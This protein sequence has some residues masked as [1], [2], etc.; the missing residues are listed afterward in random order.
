MKNSKFII[1][2][3]LTNK[4]L[5]YFQNSHVAETGLRD[6]HKMISSFL[7]ACSSKLRTKVIYLQ[8]LQEMY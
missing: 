7:K 2:L 3:I 8:K 1:D 5:H 4:P 6:Y